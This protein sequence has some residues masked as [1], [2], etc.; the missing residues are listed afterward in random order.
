MDSNDSD[1]DDDDNDGVGVDLNYLTD[2]GNGSQ[3]SHLNKHT[4]LYALDL[5]EVKRLT[6][7]LPQFL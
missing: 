4:I 7:F 1:D 3:Q 5:K 6:S 2:L